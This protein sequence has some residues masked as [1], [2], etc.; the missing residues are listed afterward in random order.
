MVRIPA[1]ALRATAVLG[2]AAALAVSHAA[3]AAAATASR[4][5][6][7]DRTVVAKAGQNDRALSAAM[8]LADNCYVETQFDRLPD[9]KTVS[10]LVHECD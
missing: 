5:G 10:R 3:F 1:P 9:G 4:P 7:I 8:T 2:I 6:Q